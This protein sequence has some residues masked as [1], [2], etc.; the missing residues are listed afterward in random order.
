MT[1]T[2][3]SR[4]PGGRGGTRWDEVDDLLAEPGGLASSQAVR[5]V[6]ERR[7]EALMADLAGSG[8]PT[9][10]Q[11][12][13]L[14]LVAAN[15]ATGQ[16]IAAVARNL[17]MSERTL[18]RRAALPETQAMIVEQRRAVAEGIRDSLVM[19]AIAGI[20]RLHFTIVDT[21]APPAAA[22]NAARFVVGLAVGDGGLAA[23]GSLVDPPAEGE[24][25]GTCGHRDPTTAEKAEAQRQFHARLDEVRRNLA[26]RPPDHPGP[27][28]AA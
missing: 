1:T 21:D 9:D 14:Q 12:A 11:T 13:E 23:L 8:T 5:P 26:S 19:A 25:C 27:T 24:A 3:S 6:T 22:V 20:D 18:H 10:A 4:R 17:G 16:S 7:M 28:S 2:T 15:L